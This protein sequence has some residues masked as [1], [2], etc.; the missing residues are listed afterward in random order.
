MKSISRALK[1]WH[2][3]SKWIGFKEATVFL[4]STLF[5]RRLLRKVNIEH[6]DLYLR[7]ASPD[8]AV[9]VS[10][11]VAEEFC[12]IKISA[13]S[14]IIDA[15]ANIGTAAI[16]F[17][18]KYPNAKVFAI[19][20]EQENYDILLK[21]IDKYKNIIPIKAALWGQ[22]EVRV[23]QDRFTGPWGYTI[24]ETANEKSATAQ[25]IE[26]LTIGSLLQRHNLHN[27]DILK[28]DIE[29]AEK[30]VLENSDAWINNVT[31]IIAELHDRICMGCD[32][33][34]YLSTREFARFE[35]SGEK[36]TAYRNEE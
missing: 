35:R 34:F 24:A 12:N 22:N 15:G 14:V 4:M 20:P 27:I 11:L 23:L 9:A 13:P 33:A 32:R 25:R 2:R 36:I 26:C 6:V 29:G 28:L 17:A 30:S 16:Y 21:N 1:A 10:C 5:R 8:L 31:I 18:R 7:T 3:Y 19:E